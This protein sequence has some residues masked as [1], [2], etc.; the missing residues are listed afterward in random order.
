MFTLVSAVDSNIVLLIT[1]KI[2]IDP[3]VGMI[4]VVMST[5]AT[6]FG[7]ECMNDSCRYS[8]RLCASNRN[9]YNGKYLSNDKKKQQYKAFLMLQ[10]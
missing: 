9:P 10:Q 7:E 5:G 3:T 8:S 1:N 2:C 4:E 6:T